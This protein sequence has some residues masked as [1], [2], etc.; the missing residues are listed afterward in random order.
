ME[1]AIEW[2]GVSGIVKIVLCF[3]V[4]FFMGYFVG[5]KANQRH[6]NLEKK[7]IKEK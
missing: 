4:V 5:R 2:E 3:A 7:I 1:I 6:L